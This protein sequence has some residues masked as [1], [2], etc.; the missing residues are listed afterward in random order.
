M[1]LK[2]CAAVLLVAG[3][4]TAIAEVDSGG[5]MAESVKRMWPA[6]VISTE[7]KPGA[8]SYEEGVLLDGM[9]AQWWTTANGS[10][11]AYVRAAVD[12]YVGADGSIKGFDARARSLDEIEMGR[13]V[14]MLYRVTRAPKYYKAAKLLRD[15]LMAQPRTESGG[16]WHK[17]IYPNQMWLDGAYMAEPFLAEYAATFQEPADLDEVAKQ[18]LLMDSHMRDLET[19]LLRHGWDESRQMAWADKGTGLSPEAWARANGWYAMALVDVLDWVPI[20]YPRRGELLEALNKTAAS[21]LAYQDKSTGLWWQVMDK[22]GQPG[23]FPEAS[24]SSMFTYALAKGVRMRYLAPSYQDTAQKGWDGIGK[25]FVKTDASG[26]ERLT[27][28]VK[29]AGLGGKPYRA[30]T[31][32]YYIG[33]KVID[34]DAKGVGAFLMAGS[35]MAQ[36]GTA[37]LGHG[38]TAVVDA[39]FNSQ[40]RVNAAGQTELFHYKW[41]DDSNDG[42]AFFGRAF[43]RYG[44]ELGELKG[45]PTADGLKAADVYLIV[46]PDTPAKNPKAHFMDKPSGDAIQAWVE[47][48]GVLVLMANDAGN[49][50]FEHFNTL[51]DRFGIHFNPVDRNKVEGSDFEQGEVMIP[52]G[53]NVFTKAHTTFMKDVCTIAVSRGATAVLTDKGDVLM[54]AAVV[55]K[56]TVFAV[57]D[58]WLYNEYTDGRKLPAKFD[59]YAAGI[60]LVGWLFKQMH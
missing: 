17:G 57:V 50:E 46:S 10:D 48:G 14:L 31:Y 23:N 9:T 21:A 34:N 45:A 43:Q 24:A 2:V 16:F 58:P 20:G 25:T 22:G 27:G 47:A 28:T 49:T 8:W 39:W 52:A 37:L 4:G 3:C 13:S 44:M 7:N 12:K 5:A 56:G 54:A 53:T 29:S 15:R 1:V 40:T 36:S 41:D 11:F 19:G 38:R 35:E 51:G 59:T 26:G 32:E 42:F 60:D 18:L 55:G 33:E 30:G 6:G